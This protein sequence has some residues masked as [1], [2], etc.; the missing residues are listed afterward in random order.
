MVFA[1]RDLR[2]PIKM[3]ICFCME[4]HNEAQSA[5]LGKN[6]KVVIMF[7][8]ILSLSLF[9]SVLIIYEIMK[10][11]RFHFVCMC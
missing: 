8:M 2:I 4:T 7:I 5:A 9:L 6:G 11:T 10:S 1:H 3:K